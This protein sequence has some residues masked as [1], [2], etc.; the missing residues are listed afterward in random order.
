MKQTF[1]LVIDVSSSRLSPLEDLSML[2]GEKAND[3]EDS[4][5][6]PYVN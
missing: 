6:L 2:H 1:P 4:F 3:L 5:R